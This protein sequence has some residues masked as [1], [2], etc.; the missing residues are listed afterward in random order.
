MIKR[1]KSGGFVSLFKSS[2]KLINYNINLEVIAIDTYKSF[3]EKL[4]K[5]KEFSIYWNKTYEPN[6][7]K[8]DEFLKTNFEKNQ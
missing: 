5:K 6:F 7:L 3:F 8:F 2:K 4:F 1:L